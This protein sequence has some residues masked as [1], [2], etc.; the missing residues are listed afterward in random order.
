MSTL[1]N[2]LVGNPN[3]AQ[4]AAAAS[5]PSGPP[6]TA[7]IN[8]P[9]AGAP[10]AVPFQPQPQVKGP[11]PWQRAVH[12]LLGSQT[13]YQQTPNGPVPVQVQNKPGQLFRSILAGAILGAGAGTANAEHNAGSGW[14]AAGAGARTVAQDQQQQQQQRQQQAQQQF[15]NQRQANQD[16][17]QELVRKAQI[18]QANAETLRINK[19]LQGQDFDQHVKIAD[20][21]RAGIKPYEDAGISP[22][23]QN[24]TESQ[25]HQ[26]IQ[27]HPEA[28]TYDWE[29][30]SVKTVMTKDANGN[31]VPTYESVYSAYDPKGKVTVPASTIAEWKK[32]GVFDRYPE[33]EA[34][35]SNNRT[36]PASTYV[37]V[38]GD[39]NK[40]IADNLTKQN[41]QLE[42]T[43]KQTQID[44]A[45]AET[46][47][48]LAAAYNDSISAREKQ[49]QE[50]EKNA[51]NTAWDHLAAAG[52]DPN[53]A[54]MTAQDRITIARNIQ[55][56]IEQERKNIQESIS[57]PSQTEEDRAPMWANLHAFEALAQL[58]A[59]QAAGPVAHPDVVTI[60]SQVPGFDP[61]I[62][63][64]IANLSPDEIAS[65]LQSATGIPEDVKNKILTSIGK[66]S[67]NTKFD[68]VDENGNVISPGGGWTKAE[69]QQLNDQ[70]KTNGM[71]SV[72]IKGPTKLLPPVSPTLAVY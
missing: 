71:P 68:V 23:A 36:L 38:K 39:A 37:Q 3:I 8:I 44:A 52:N 40:V 21:G 60:L 26:Y 28:S 43:L 20:I 61:Q 31:E 32:A 30:V 18:A 66:T 67:D 5:G 59:T 14:G 33:Y 47:E 58:G 19:E 16:Q 51:L 63:Q 15:E 45:K 1:V 7:P 50:K 34:A 2:P 54:P 27:D 65:Q 57:D 11:S 56:A 22:V 24:I 41:Q 62:A 29:P 55:P 46:K 35:L 49:D 42:T 6:P 12:A 64:K 53:K 4:Q 70:R 9:N 13:E 48:R 72:T 17:Q 69:I 25:M 10:P